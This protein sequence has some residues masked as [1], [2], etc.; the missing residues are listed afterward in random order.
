MYICIY[1]HTHTHIYIYIYIHVHACMYIYDYSCIR[2][3]LGK[4]RNQTDAIP[5]SL[6]QRSTRPACVGIFCVCRHLLPTPSRPCVAV[7]CSVLR[8]VA[9]VSCKELGVTGCKSKR[10]IGIGCKSLM[11]NTCVGKDP[12]TNRWRGERQ[13]KCGCTS[14]LA[15]TCVANTCVAN[16]R[17]WV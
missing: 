12:Y 10:R 5:L 17:N 7:C 11:A 8:S 4:W 13:H 15:N 1:T 9:E 2:I 3:V 6:V 16:T 14:L